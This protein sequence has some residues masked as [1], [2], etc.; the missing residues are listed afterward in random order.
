LE[1][2]QWKIYDILLVFHTSWLCLISFLSC[3]KVLNNFAH[4]SCLCCIVCT[5]ED[6]TVRIRQ[7]HLMWIKWTYMATTNPISVKICD[8]VGTNW[9][10]DVVL[11]QRQIFKISDA[12]QQE[13]RYIGTYQ[14]QWKWFICRCTESLASM[15]KI[16]WPKFIFLCGPFWVNIKCCF[17]S[18]RPAVCLSLHLSGCSVP[19]IYSKSESHI[20]DLLCDENMSLHINNWEAIL[21]G[22]IYLERKCAIH[23]CA[24]LSKV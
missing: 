20:R 14:T 15:M 11:L 9:L 19:A 3:S 5:V 24:C 18:I 16:I 6:E 10:P 23:F 1:I 12:A 22:W 21:R 13:N 4:S 17:L 8:S 7:S 2:T